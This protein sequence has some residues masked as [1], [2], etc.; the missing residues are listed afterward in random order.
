MSQSCSHWSDSADESPGCS[1]GYVITAYLSVR[2]WWFLQASRREIMYL[3][4]L[5][6]LPGN[7][8]PLELIF[9]LNVSRNQSCSFSPP[10][11]LT[12]PIIRYI[13]GLE[14]MVLHWVCLAYSAVYWFDLAAIC[15]RLLTIH[16]RGSVCSAFHQPFS[17]S[18]ICS[19]NW[20][21]VTMSRQ[22]SAVIWETSTQWLLSIGL[23]SSH[24]PPMW[25]SGSHSR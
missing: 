14:P 13:F 5:G 19:I 22:A 15:F 7:W 10:Q 11:Y 8:W 3:T 16:F 9:E 2:F 25:M 4:W 24:W 21:W 20:F 17:A 6:P 23:S 12:W 18:I 1:E